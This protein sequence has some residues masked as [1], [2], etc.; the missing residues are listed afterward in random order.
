MWIARGAR[1]CTRALGFELP[2]YGS[3]LAHIPGFPPRARRQVRPGGPPRGRG[4]AGDPEASPLRAAKLKIHFTI[5]HPSCQPYIQYSLAQLEEF[6][7]IT[8]IF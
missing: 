4:W 6:F 1:D 8:K 2:S 7:G 3:R 5:Y